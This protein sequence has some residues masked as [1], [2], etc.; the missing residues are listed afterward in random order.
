MV[1]GE[2]RCSPVFLE[3]LLSDS[4]GEAPRGQQKSSAEFIITSLA[5]VAG[6]LVQIPLFISAKDNKRMHWSASGAK[7]VKHTMSG[8]GK[9]EQK[10]REVERKRKC[11]ERRIKTCKKVC[12]F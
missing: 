6:A 11:A 5:R 12:W 3:A 4:L 7:R 1:L 9:I 8:E 10:I 2:S